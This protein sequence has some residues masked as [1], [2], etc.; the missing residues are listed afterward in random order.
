MALD[1]G[2]GEMAAPA[3]SQ[4]VTIDVFRRQYPEY[5]DLTDQKVAEMLHSKF[6]SDMPQAE[7]NKKFGVRMADGSWGSYLKGLGRTAFGSATFSFGDEIE[8]AARGLLRGEPYGKTVESIRRQ[9]EQFA[10]EN[11]GSAI[12]A[13]LAGGVI[14]F[15]GPV[16]AAT[17]LGQ[18]ARWAASGSSMARTAGRSAV[19]GAGAGAAAGLGA[20]EGG[21]PERLGSAG[22]G[23]AAGAVLGGVVPPVF[24]GAGRAIGGLAE[25]GADAAAD[26]RA[27]WQNLRGAA[28]RPAPPVPPVTERQPPIA[29]VH[30]VANDMTPQPATAQDEAL[31]LLRDQLLRGGQNIGDVESQMQAASEARRF[32]SS[33]LAQGSTALVDL[34][35]AWQRLAGSMW[36]QY[37]E[38]AADMNRFINARQTGFTT[39]TAN[40]MEMAQRG[41]PTRERFSQPLT[42][43]QAKEVLGSP[44]ATPKA[45]LVP[46]GHV[47]RIRDALRRAFLISDKDYHGHARTG[48][49]TVEQIV[50]GAEEAAQ[51][52]YDAAFDA[53]PTLNL[54][55]V[56]GPVFRKHLDL[57]R[58]NEST[59]TEAYLDRARGLFFR[60]GAP[61]YL[62][63][64]D[65]VKRELDG[66]I[67]D[68]LAKPKYVHRGGVLMQLK[69]DL[70]DAVDNA[71]GGA[72]SP[73]AAARQEFSDSMSMARAYQL[74]R[75]A[76]DERQTLRRTGPLQ[77]LNAGAEV[78]ADQFAQLSPG[79][80]KL[81]RF[82]ILDA[83]TAAAM[84]KPREREM[85]A[86]FQTPRVQELLQTAVPKTPGKAAVFSDRPQ[87]FGRYLDFERQMLDTR[88]T[89]RGNSMTA[90]NLAD[91]RALEALETVNGMKD[92]LAAAGGALS[93]AHGNPFGLMGIVNSVGNVVSRMFGMPADT[94]RE[95]SRMLFTANPTEQQAI[96][97]RLAAIMPAERM[98]RFNEVMRQ[99]QARLGVPGVG[100]AGI[101]GGA[102]A[103]NQPTM[104]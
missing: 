78:T 20:G 59:A 22:A 67:K 96:V 4:P 99:L 69:N 54:R 101:A 19:L 7:F 33:G 88:D 41:L 31:A 26:A 52:S 68:D 55:S 18:A 32:H 9:N 47:E 72:S 87:R 12:I 29:G 61:V 93:L 58:A 92:A 86:L 95:L 66:M 89:V 83:V 77:E 38:A 100:A 62:R 90:R 102:A 16:G 81:A 3:A 21:L 80:Q 48:L 70:L 65:Q 17:R 56:I 42:G 50:S 103:G 1:P 24:A 76:L 11:P 2:A 14:P 64:F 13:S 94:A 74:G 46:M 91:D 28:P 15:T 53:Y 63:Q 5:G 40:P 34:V 30:F 49:R 51:G 45:G 39:K 73:Y 82:G 37:P 85:L 44:F 25:A 8:A 57:A 36:R 79:Q 10:E 98:Q 60:K 6:Y 23:A 84:R 104:L 43:A 27:A 75:R 71:T 35:P 97:R